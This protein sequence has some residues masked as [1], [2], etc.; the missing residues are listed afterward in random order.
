MIRTNEYRTDA[1]VM[2]RGRWYSAIVESDG[3]ASITSIDAD[4]N[5]ASISGSYL[6]FPAGFHMVDY[7]LD[8]TTTGAVSAVSVNK[9]LRLYADG[10]QGLTL[11]DAG[12]YQKT[13]VN[14]FGYFE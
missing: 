3:T 2:N 12:D 1:P 11:P 14:V 9:A 5:T 6:K 13:V 8:V 10:S 7:L 4:I